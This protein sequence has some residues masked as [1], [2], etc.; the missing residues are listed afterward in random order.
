MGV[1]TEI[2]AI[3]EALHAYYYTRNER[4]FD[5]AEKFLLKVHDKYGTIDIN[6]IK[7][8]LN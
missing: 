3:Q 6:I 8:L 5:M 4:E 7:S 2:G 1:K